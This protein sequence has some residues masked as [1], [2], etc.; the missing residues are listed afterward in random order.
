M[1]CLVKC[2]EKSRVGVRAR[3]QMSLC[4]GLI[5]GFFS[6]SAT[7]FGQWS[8]NL[9]YQNPHIATYGVNFLLMSK[10]LAVEF[11]LGW[12]DGEAVDTDGKNSNGDQSTDQPGDNDTANIRVAGDIDLKYFFT[13]GAVKPFLQGG[14]G[15]G[16]GASAGKNSGLGF[17]TGSGFGGLGLFLDMKSFYVYGSYN[18]NG[19]Q[20]AFVQ[21]GLGFP[22]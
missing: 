18:L 11:G 6:L 10:P 15:Y 17:S 12:V 13:D 8:W 5:M 21:G 7:A 16:L 20:T 9:G 4:F 2:L 1:K 3:Q 19:Y 22:L 14:V